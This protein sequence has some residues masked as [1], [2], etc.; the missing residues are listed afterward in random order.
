MLDGARGLPALGAG[1]VRTGKPNR[2]G[3]TDSCEDRDRLLLLA[4]T[5]E[6]VEAA[7]PSG[8]GLIPRGCAL[9]EQAARTSTPSARLRGMQLEIRS[10][11]RASIPPGMHALVR[12][13][14]RAMP[15]GEAVLCDCGL[16]PPQ[17]C[18]GDRDRGAQTSELPRRRVQQATAGKTVR[19]GQPNAGGQAGGGQRSDKTLRHVLVAPG[20]GSVCSSSSCKALETDDRSAS[21]ALAY[22]PG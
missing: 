1:L 18:R 12:S 16:R 7:Q 19:S 9:Q 22:T 17:A 8:A 13:E 14:N 6:V 21:S 5:E 2:F 15:G 11:I 20:A 10:S 4:E 3:S